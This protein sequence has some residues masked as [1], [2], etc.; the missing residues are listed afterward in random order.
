MGPCSCRCAWY[1]LQVR[2]QQGDLE[3]LLRQPPSSDKTTDSTPHHDY[4][5]RIMGCMK[6]SI[7]C[8]TALGPHFPR[9]TSQQPAARRVN[10]CALHEVALALQSPDSNP[11]TDYV[12]VGRLKA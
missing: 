12:W 7:C 3:S 11:E 2:F 1:Y 9:V 4:F 6:V 5:W 8:K 10:A